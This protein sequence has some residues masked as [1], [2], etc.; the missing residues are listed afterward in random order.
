MKKSKTV[1]I[2]EL[3][4]EVDDLLKQAL[5]LGGHKNP[6]FTRTIVDAQ[7]LLDDAVV[8]ADKRQT[9]LPKED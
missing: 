4:W 2:V 3:L 7:I 5:K 9:L 8:Y 6:Q 1:K